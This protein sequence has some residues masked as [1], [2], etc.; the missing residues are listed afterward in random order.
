MSE[1]LDV[2]KSKMRNIVVLSL[3]LQLLSQNQPT[4]KRKY[5]AVGLIKKKSLIVIDTQ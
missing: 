1:C 4:T 5:C 2:A 3:L